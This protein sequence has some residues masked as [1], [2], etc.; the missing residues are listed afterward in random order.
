MPTK[1]GK[2][3]KLKYEAEGSASVHIHEDGCMLC[4]DPHPVVINYTNTCKKIY[5]TIFSTK[6]FS[7][8]PWI[9]FR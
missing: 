5:V 9:I 4:Y 8:V 6:I 7:W 2:E 1:R 3:Y